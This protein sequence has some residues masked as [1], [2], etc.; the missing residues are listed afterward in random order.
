MIENLLGSFLSAINSFGKEAFSSNLPFE[1]M[2]HHDFSIVIRLEK[3]LL[4][5]YVFKGQSYS[6]TRKITTIAESVKTKLHRILDQ[7]TN[8][9]SA[10]VPDEDPDMNLLIDEIIYSASPT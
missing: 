6:G 5:C 2:K 4:F 1:R 3:P 10:V 7:L 9:F 8:P